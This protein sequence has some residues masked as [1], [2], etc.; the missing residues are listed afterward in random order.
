MELYAVLFLAAIG[1]GYLTVRFAR[2]R[3]AVRGNPTGTTMRRSVHVV[4]ANQKPW[5][6]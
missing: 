1:I 3:S 5:G 4:G 6:W 2:T